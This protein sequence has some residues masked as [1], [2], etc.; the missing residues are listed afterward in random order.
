VGG[1]V[2][3]SVCRSHGVCVWVG[4]WEGV[5]VGGCGGV[6]VCVCVLVCAAAT[7]THTHKTHT[8]THTHRSCCRL[9]LAAGAD[10][11]VAGVHAK[12]SINRLLLLLIISR[13]L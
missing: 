7:R 6:W 1:C 9:R 8:H 10:G 3:L 11:F 4:G 12:S 2:C 13:L 5:C